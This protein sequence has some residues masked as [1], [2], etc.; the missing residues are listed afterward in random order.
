[1][2][3]GGE[4]DCLLGG[5]D[6]RDSIAVMVR[7]YV[8]QNKNRFLDELQRLVRQPSVS[9]TGDGV[10]ECALL[11]KEMM[12]AAGAK[13]QIIDADGHAD[14]PLLIGEWGPPSA[15]TLSLYAHYDT[16]PPA[17]P[18]A[19]TT[20]PYSPD[21]RHGRMYGAGV[22]DDKA[23]LFT[24]V[25][26]VE[27]LERLGIKSA[28]LKFVFDGE[29]EQ[30]SPHFPA[31][32][33]TN[34]ELLKA[35]LLLGADSDA[36]EAGPLIALGLKGTLF[37]KL[38]VSTADTSMPTGFSEVVPNALWRLVEVLASMRDDSGRVLIE[39]FY[40][41][42]QAITPQ[43]ELLLAKLPFDKAGVQ[44]ALQ[45]R[46]LLADDGPDYYRRLYMHPT[47]AL[48][49][50]TGGYV[51]E[52]VKN[53]LPDTAYVTADIGIMPD[54]TCD[55]IEEKL[56]LHVASRGFDDVKVTVLHK[57]GPHRIPV[58]HPYVDVVKQGMRRA[59]GREAYVTP[60]LRCS[61]GIGHEFAK[62]GIPGMWIPCLHPGDHNMHG[63]DE[64]VR[65]EDLVDGIVAKSVVCNQFARLG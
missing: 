28:R 22:A 55:E 56:R 57:L 62:M 42:V 19:W 54:Q 47:F 51:G 31:F 8:E 20:P 14:Y 32:A 7:E 30:Y 40:D 50:I 34:Q 46:W 15:V 44:R 11:V 45:A 6:V 27:A 2:A 37:V 9:A 23:Q 21:I 10:R 43:E 13:T 29:E 12:D 36:H 3:I 33:A 49:G 35:D 59:Y 24:I 17:D 61:G 53:A 63:V 58:D 65:I 25:K 16:V 38:E 1:M 4:T 41:N 64:N 39:G 60:C 26:A 5:R 52:G 48:T 18:A